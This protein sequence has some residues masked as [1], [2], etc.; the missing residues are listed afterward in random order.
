[1]V[2]AKISPRK[3]Q[4]E[5]VALQIFTANRLADGAVVFL[6]GDGRW[7]EKPS[8]DGVFDASQEARMRGLAEAAAATV[9]VDPYLIEVAELDGDIK[10]LRYREWIR[11]YGPPCHPDF[12]KTG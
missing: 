1:M 11:A 12:A 3:T 5:Q 8:L 4:E 7:S 9:V 6:G 10:L 2:F